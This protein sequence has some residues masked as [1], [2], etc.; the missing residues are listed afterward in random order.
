MNFGYYNKMPEPLKNDPSRNHYYALPLILGV[1]GMIW[2]FMK[3]KN[4]ANIIGLLFF[5][6][7]IAIV[8]YLNQTPQQPRERDYSYAG[9]FQTFC[10]WIGLG[11]LALI[12]WAKNKEFKKVKYDKV[13]SRL[14]LLSDPT[15]CDLSVPT[16]IKVHRMNGGSLDTG[17]KDVVCSNVGCSSKDGVCQKM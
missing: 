2:H 7:G 8:L 11:V 5:F 10:Y 6:T 16:G 14:E 4:D 9:S 3:N 13:K 1:I 17:V 12:D 15:S